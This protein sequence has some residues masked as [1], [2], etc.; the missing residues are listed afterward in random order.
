MAVRFPALT[1]TPKTIDQQVLTEDMAPS[2]LELTER[3]HCRISTD[4]HG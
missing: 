2:L 4:V 3:R 1:K